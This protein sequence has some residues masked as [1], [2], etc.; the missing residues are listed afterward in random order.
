MDAERILQSYF[1]VASATLMGYDYLLTVQ[2]EADL[3]WRSNWSLVKILFFLTR[4]S[5]FVDVVLDLSYLVSPKMNAKTC[6]VSFLISRWL[7]V[8]GIAFSETILV[9]RTWVLWDKRKSILIATLTTGIGSLLCAITVVGIWTKSMLDVY[10]VTPR[11]RT[12]PGCAV[13]TGSPIVALSLVA[14]ILIETVLLILTVVRMF[15]QLRTSGRHF[16]NWTPFRVL[17]RDGIT[18]F[19]YLLAISMV[20]FIVIVAGPPV[21]RDTLIVLQRVL[22]SSLTARML[23]NL[24]EAHRT[25]GVESTP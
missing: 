15:Q 3:V 10:K 4:Y 24:R 16:V 14:V 11:H 6:L 21:S 17:Y 25:A 23:L 8:F 1:S 5:A 7:L 12:V 22:H 20:N 13:L 2:R 19:V 18:F 9:I